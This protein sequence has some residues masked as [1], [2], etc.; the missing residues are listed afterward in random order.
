L[1]VSSAL[2]GSSAV[3][4]GVKV[5]YPKL[6]KRLI[7]ALKSSEFGTEFADWE[8]IDVKD[9][10]QD[11]TKI[12]SLLSLNPNQA[13]ILI[14]PITHSSLH[15]NTLKLKIIGTAVATRDDIFVFRRNEDPQ[16][17]PSK[18]PYFTIG[19]KD[20]DITTTYAFLLA[21]SRWDP[22]AIFHS[23]YKKM[24]PPIIQ[25]A[26]KKTLEN[27]KIV[28]NGR[29]KFRG[30]DSH[31]KRYDQLVNNKDKN[32]SI[33]AAIFT[34]DELTIKKNRMNIELFK[35]E[36][37]VDTMNVNRIINNIYGIRHFPRA[38]ML[39]SEADLATHKSN[40]DNF[41]REY[42]NRIGSLDVKLSKVGGKH[43]ARS[44]ILCKV[45]GECIKDHCDVAIKFTTAICKQPISTMRATDFFTEPNREQLSE[46]RG[47][48]PTD[49]L[50]FEE[51]FY[52]KWKYAIQKSVAGLVKDGEFGSALDKNAICKNLEKQDLELASN[53]P[54]NFD[55][56]LEGIGKVD[57]YIGNALFGVNSESL[58]KKI[59]KGAKK[60]VNDP[61]L[62]L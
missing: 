21:M 60:N 44:Q 18:I 56:I 51:L 34:G 47:L 8:L 19:V 61:A 7:E 46:A 45:G 59:E 52:D 14:L 13:N 37:I 40:I 62:F 5:Y 49:F 23:N 6:W 35:D 1:I 54:M 31:V 33:D 43:I 57:N 53:H 32:E 41:I 29:Y 10:G 16:K 9:T 15:I 24:G 48:K 11:G 50:H 3:K 28:M 36:N 22:D 27:V 2:R 17:T 26:Y 55:N 58:R 30:V 39:V 25:D 20:P 12:Q 38:L 4:N 42:N